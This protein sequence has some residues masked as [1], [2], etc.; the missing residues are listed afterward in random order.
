MKNKI[1]IVL[2]VYN[3]EK[4]IKLTLNS[5]KNQTSKDFS[6]IIIDNKSND[7]TN[8]IC[9]SFCENYSWASLFTNTETLSMAENWNKFIQYS[10]LDYVCMI[11][12]DDYYENQ[13]VDKINNYLKFN[14]PDLIVFNANIVDGK[15][16]LKNQLSYNKSN[17]SKED[18]LITFPGIQ[19]HVWKRNKISTKFEL[20]YFPIFDYIWFYNNLKNLNK[21]DYLNEFLVNITSDENQTT[22]KVSWEFGV[23]KALNYVIFDEKST[24]RTAAKSHLLFKLKSLIY[25][26]LNSFYKKSNK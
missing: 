19:R 9:K 3:G 23:L 17:L 7:N 12:A 4:S 16:N 11:H 2:P 1:N 6:L 24:L 14:N 15:Q 8:Q 13:F 18:Y 5:L 21:I 10:N 22:N 26:R 25:R 20:Y